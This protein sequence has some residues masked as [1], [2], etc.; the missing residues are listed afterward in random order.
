[1]LCGALSTRTDDVGTVLHGSRTRT[2]AAGI[3]RRV[4]YIKTTSVRLDEPAIGGRFNVTKNKVYGALRDIYIFGM[5]VAGFCLL[6][7]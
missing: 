1:M 7:E 5:I 3:T 4:P 6:C 2:W